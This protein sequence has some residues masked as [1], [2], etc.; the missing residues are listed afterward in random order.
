MKAIVT[1]YHSAT[2]TKGSRI[3]ARAEQ[4]GPKFY[5]YDHSSDDPHRD[6][7]HDYAKSKGWLRDGTRLVG[8]GLPNGDQCWVFVTD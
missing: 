2:N 7:A 8:G 3:S 4:N 5:P 1:K 6:A